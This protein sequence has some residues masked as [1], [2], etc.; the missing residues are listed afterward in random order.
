LHIYREYSVDPQERAFVDEVMSTDVVTIPATS[1]L[2]DVAEHYFGAV[3]RHRG[4]PV[5]DEDGAL[6][7]MLDRDALSTGLKTLGEAGRAFELFDDSK[8][9]IAL[10]TETCQ[11]AA[12]RMAAEKL[13]RLPVVADR[14]SLR[15]VGILS[16]S[17]LIKPSHYVFHEEHV[18][19]RLFN[20]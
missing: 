2:G 1:T 6:I 17:D 3:Q 20:Q 19:E 9:P 7:G 10:P 11:M 13:E 8:P 16:R 4:F 14:K 5:V 18:R 12:R 15:L